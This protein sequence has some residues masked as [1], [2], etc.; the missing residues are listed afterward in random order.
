MDTL[1]YIETVGMDDE[2]VA[3]H[4]QSAP[5]GVLALADDRESYAIPVAHAF[6]DGRLYVRLTDDGR[7]EKLAYLERTERATFVCYGESGDTSWSVLVRGRLEEV[8]PSRFDENPFRTIRLFDED[9]SELEVRLF[10]F[11]DPDITGRRTAGEDPWR[12][13]LPRHGW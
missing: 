4:L 7:S 6:E 9:A 2:E 3:G 13:V 10:A 12:V 8:P 5:S 1:V 11:V